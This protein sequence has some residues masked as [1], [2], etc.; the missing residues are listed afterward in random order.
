MKWPPKPESGPD[1][2]AI[3]I[4]DFKKGIE[5]SDFDSIRELAL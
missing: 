5:D 4:S 3:F 1:L 2:S